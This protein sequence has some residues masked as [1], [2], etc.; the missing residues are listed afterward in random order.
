[1]RLKIARNPDD[2]RR[3][4]TLPGFSTCRYPQPNWTRIA[5]GAWLSVKWEAGVLKVAIVVGCFGIGGCAQEMRATA[6]DECAEFGARP[7]SLEFRE[8]RQLQDERRLRFGA[9]LIGVKQSPRLPI[10]AV[11]RLP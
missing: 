8:C 1:V 7:C 10:D 11:V 6:L 4:A 5:P 9:S 3:D 2:G